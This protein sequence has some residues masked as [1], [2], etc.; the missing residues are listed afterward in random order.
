VS[1]DDEGRV[2]GEG[3]LAAQTTQVMHNLG[4]ALKPPVRAIPTS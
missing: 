1:T 3:D 4:L 2:V